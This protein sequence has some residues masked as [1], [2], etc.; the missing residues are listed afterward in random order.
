MNDPG[1]SELF[2][3]LAELARRHPHWRI[4]QWV[5]N[6]AGWADADPW[7]V[8]DEQLLSTARAHL[9]GSDAADRA[10]HPPAHMI[11]TA[12]NGSRTS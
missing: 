5:R 1:R 12:T 9:H 10:P 11:S 8:E 3:A 6:A 4:G 2:A 7:E